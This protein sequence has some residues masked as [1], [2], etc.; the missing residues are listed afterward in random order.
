M[1]GIAIHNGKMYMVTVKEVFVAPILPD[2]T[3][4]ELTQIIGDLPD[5]G[6]HFNRVL[7]VGPDDKLYI[8]IGSTTNV[9]N[10][11]NQENA[12][13]V[14]A[15]LDGTNRRIFAS[16]LRNT[17]G[18][19]WHPATKRMWGWDQGIDWLGDNEQGEEFNE[20]LEG[21][22]YGWPYV[23]G[24]SELHPHVRPPQEIGLTNADWAKQ[25]R[26]PTLL[27]TAHSAG[28]QMAFYTGTMFPQEYQNDAFV[29]L[30][31]SWNRNP[32]SGYE[33]VRVHFDKSGT[34]T[35]IEPFLTGFLVKGADPTGNGKD[36]QFARLAGCAVAR[37]GSLLIGDDSNN[38]IYRVWY[39][40]DAPP[41]PIMRREAISMNLPESEPKSA[42]QVSVTSPA[43]KNN[44]AIPDENTSYFQDKSP[45]LSWSGVPGETKAVAVMMEDPDASTK[46]ITHFIAVLPASITRL[47]AG[48]PKTDTLP[49]GGVQGGNVTGAVGYYGPHPPAGDKPHHYHFQ[50]FALDAMP[51][52]PVGF[53]RQALLDAMQNHVLAKGETIGT[54]QRTPDVRDKP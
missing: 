51:A 39:G 15:N 33:V 50:V 1:H 34:A 6:Q 26:E 40:R 16:G 43:F 3:L 14:R 21:Q 49:V 20:I 54:Y 38:T 12:T 10:E 23:Y 8:S 53:N 24:K 18:F 37:D 9:A 44:G 30:R 4:G 32:P 25:S 47:E 46:P 13:I 42:A 17:I 35:K 2:G 11:T 48:L 31:G 5:G 7:A 29:S 28:I 36:A 19:G 41:P 22:K 52:L 27:Y 45:A